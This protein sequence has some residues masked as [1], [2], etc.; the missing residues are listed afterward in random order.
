M[1]FICSGPTW[2]LFNRIIKKINKLNIIK[3][4]SFKIIKTFFSL[5]H[6]KKII[7]NEGIKNKK[8]VWEKT[9][10][11]EKK[12]LRVL[13]QIISNNSVNVFERYLDNLQ[14]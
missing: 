4:I 8:P 11:A 13:Y 12:P 10:T 1:S 2:V 7:K 6:N 5:L 14:T 3:K 9:V